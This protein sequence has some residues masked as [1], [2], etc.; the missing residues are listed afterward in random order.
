MN[1]RTFRFLKT[2]NR[3][4]TSICESRLVLARLRSRNHDQVFRPGRRGPS[5]CK[6]TA[7]LKQKRLEELE[8]KENFLLEIPF[9]NNNINVEL[10]RI[11]FISENLQIVSNSDNVLISV[12]D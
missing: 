8:K 4:I 5:V 3:N 9:F 10:K 11:N 7:K 12:G 1:L 6:Q 2:R